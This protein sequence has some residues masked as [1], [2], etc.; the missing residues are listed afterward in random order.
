MTFSKKTSTIDSSYV[1]G[2]DP[3]RKVSEFKYLGVIL[4]EDL[5]FN[6]HI[7]MILNK[8]GKILSLVIR[9]LRA[10]PQLLKEA[11]YRAL[12]RPHLEYASAVWDPHQKYL[13]DKIEGVQNRAVR[14]ILNKY[15]GFQ[16][17]TQ[18]K[19][20]IE[21][22]HLDTRRR[23]CR[24]K[25]IHAIYNNL[26]GVDK[27]VYMKTPHYI[28]NRKDHSKKIREIKCQTNY[29]KFSFFPRTIGE[30]NELSADMVSVDD[31]TFFK[32]LE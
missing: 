12:V 17:V 13:M 8:A 30:W 15:S 10:A 5:T 25:L 23:K 2:R 28:S 29:V 20:C 31:E 24:L 14:F 6:H 11:A 21:M 9:N 18:M 1:I 4:S 26:T 16:N 27:S 7:D 19:A 32:T 3:L 22:E